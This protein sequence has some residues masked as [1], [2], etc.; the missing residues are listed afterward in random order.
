MEESQFDYYTVVSE[1]I[2]VVIFLMMI[3]RIRPVTR[4]HSGGLPPMEN[5]LDTV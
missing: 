1:T 2:K 4:E 5:V 3:R